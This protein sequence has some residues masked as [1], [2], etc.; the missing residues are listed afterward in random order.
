M[1]Y[2]K[3]ESAEKASMLSTFLE[4]ALTCEVRPCDSQH[5]FAKDFS[6]HRVAVPALHQADRK[7]RPV[8]PR[9]ALLGVRLGLVFVRGPEVLPSRGVRTRPFRN[10]G[11]LGLVVARD[12]GNVRPDGHMVGA[13]FFHRVI[14]VVEKRAEVARAAEK[15]RDAADANE[16]ARVTDG[17]DRFIRFAAEMFVQPGTG[18]V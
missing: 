15:T 13:E 8:G 2:I 3:Q 18:C 11:T 17:F 12:V 14:Q 5:I 4:Q 16:P 6:D 9:E 10:S 7:E 1:S